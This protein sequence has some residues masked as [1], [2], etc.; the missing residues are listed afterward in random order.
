MMNSAPSK[1]P[2]S[3][4]TT[5]TSSITMAVKLN[6]ANT[7]E[8]TSPTTSPRDALSD[9]A[10][11]NKTNNH[12]NRASSASIDSAASTT[13]DATANKLKRFSTS[14][15]CTVCNNAVY[16]TEEMRI[17]KEVIHRDCFK[18]THCNNKLSLSNFASVNKKYYC[19]PHY[20]SLFAEHGGKYDKAFGD[21]G[22]EKKAETSYSPTDQ[23]RSFVGTPPPITSTTSSSSA[24]SSPSIAPTGSAI[25]SAV[26]STSKPTV[27]SVPVTTNKD[28]T[29]G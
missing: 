10:A 14:V 22:F 4:T 17:E 11:G 29:K 21:G 3:P 25:P 15:M 20:F 1:L 7:S 12:N 8:T 24:P 5:T 26:T 16:K 13:S 28:K 6:R 2:L 9:S 27:S 19:K 18:C 23:R